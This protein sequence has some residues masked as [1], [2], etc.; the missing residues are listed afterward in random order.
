MSRSAPRSRPPARAGRNGA[1]ET[2]A[3]AEDDRVEH[4]R[5]HEKGHAVDRL[6]DRPAD[7]PLEEGELQTEAGEGEGAA[8]RADAGEEARRGGLPRPSTCSIPQRPRGKPCPAPAGEDRD[9]AAPRSRPA[10]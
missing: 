6:D 3:A 4:L 8:E 2:G 9:P 1:R 7:A 5:E 10:R